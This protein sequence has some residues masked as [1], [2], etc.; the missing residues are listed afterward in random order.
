M[1]EV[2]TQTENLE[3]AMTA[4]E[5]EQTE[6]TTETVGESDTQTQ[7]AT[8]IRWSGCNPEIEDHE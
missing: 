3:Q 2:E 1:S 8:G 5:G 6:A 7:S 4:T